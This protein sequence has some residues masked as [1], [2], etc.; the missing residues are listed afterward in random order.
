MCIEDFSQYLNWT[1]AFYNRQVGQGHVSKNSC[2]ASYF[3]KNVNLQNISGSGRGMQGCLDS[4]FIGREFNSINAFV[5]INEIMRNKGLMP[6]GAG[7]MSARH[8]KESRAKVEDL[9]NMGFSVGF[10][11]LVKK[12][13][14]GLARFRDYVSLEIARVSVK[15]KNNIHLGYREIL[16][17][18]YFVGKVKCFLGLKLGLDRLFRVVKA[19]RDATHWLDYVQDITG[20]NDVSMYHHKR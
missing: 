6:M 2:F 5:S 1:F 9:N 19:Q 16:Y 17:I 14:T 11:E 4:N 13:N 3:L 7:I 18:G 20:D 12:V 8:A 15:S 10:I